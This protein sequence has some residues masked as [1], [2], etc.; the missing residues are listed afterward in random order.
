[1]DPQQKKRFNKVFKDKFYLIH[2]NI[3]GKILEFKM[4]GSTS[5]LYTVTIKDKEIR[6]DCPDMKSWAKRFDCVCKHC[7]FVLHKVL[8]MFDEYSYFFDTLIFTDT[9]MKEIRKKT[10]SLNMKNNILVNQQ[11]RKKYKELISG[12]TKL[13]SYDRTKEVGDEDLCAIC[14]DNF[15]DKKHDFQ[16]PVCNNLTHKECVNNW[17]DHHDECVYC[18]QNIKNLYK[19]MY[20]HNYVEERDGDYINFSD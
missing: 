17:F 19:K 13:K 15:Y 14:L 12:E 6:C 5:N 10:I 11:F 4:S 8:D 9:E 2:R 3:K 16:C 20:D 7:C 18:R 1:M